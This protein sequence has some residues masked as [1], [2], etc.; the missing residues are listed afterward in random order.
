MSSFDQKNYRL[1]RGWARRRLSEVLT[2]ALL[3]AAFIFTLQIT[4]GFI[5][6]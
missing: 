1:A 5:G 4:F 3:A 2:L 6:G